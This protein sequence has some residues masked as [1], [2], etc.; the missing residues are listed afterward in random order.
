MGDEGGELAYPAALLA[1]DLLGV[2][3]ADDDVGDGR[4][5]AD[6]DAG[7]AL[8]SQLALEELVELG[9]EDTVGDELSALGDVDATE[10]R[11]GVGCGH[12]CVSLV[13]GLEEVKSASGLQVLSRRC[14]LSLLSP[15]PCTAFVLRISMSRSRVHSKSYGILMSIG[16]IP[17]T[18][19]QLTHSSHSSH[20]TVPQSVPWPLPGNSKLITAS[21]SG[22]YSL[23][24]KR[25]SMSWGSSTRESNFVTIFAHLQSAGGLKLMAWRGVE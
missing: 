23:L 19:G 17:D 22:A 1:E 18:L 5:D 9:V 25:W 11:G 20:S 13:S 14:P 6:L 2:G 8:L 4:G 7:V 16:W 21:F 3:G 10:G 12:D 15:P 24:R